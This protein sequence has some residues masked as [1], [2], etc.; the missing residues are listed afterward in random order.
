MPKRRG[1]PRREGNGCAP[2][3]EENLI[4]RAMK[5]VADR[6]GW[7]LPSL[8]L[9]VHSDIPFASGLG[10]SGAAIVAGVALCGKLCGYEFTPDKFHR[11]ATE[12]EGHADNVAAALLG[13]FVV[14]CIRENGSV[15]IVKRFWPSDLK[16][17]AVTPNIAVETK[18][19]RSILPETIRRHDAVYNLQR[20]SLFGAALE[21]QDYDLL[22]EA[23]KDRLHQSARA[24]LIPGLAQALAIP[25]LPG[26]FGLALSGSG[27]SIVA[28]ASGRLTEIG[29]VIAGCFH[30]HGVKTKVRVLE[31]DHLEDYETGLALAPIS[32][33]CENSPKPEMH[34]GN[35][36]WR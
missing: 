7:N 5:F 24:R 16:I 19:A 9:D 14:N 6:E 23:M 3:D 20:M 34:S 21:K 10:S 18:H 22:W 27:P 8:Y 35:G 26:L 2:R 4:Y 25:R 11:Y 28:L 31:V 13:G 30:D 17:I 33:L 29:K 32:Q 12:L 15:I 1:R 36:R